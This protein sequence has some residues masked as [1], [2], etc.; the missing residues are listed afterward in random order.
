MAEVESSAFSML[1]FEERPAT[2]LQERSGGELV[3]GLRL[4][5]SESNSCNV[6]LDQVQ[7]WIK[8]AAIAIAIGFATV[9]D[10]NPVDDPEP[11][12]SQSQSQSLAIYMLGRSS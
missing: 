8:V 6:W 9:S 5:E 7:L 4:T 1:A 11:R 12:W 10:C 2:A 3:D